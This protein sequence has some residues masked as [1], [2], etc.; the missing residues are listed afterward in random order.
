MMIFIEATDLSSVPSCSVLVPIEQY[1][2][3]L[4]FQGPVY[5]RYRQHVFGHAFLH[6]ADEDARQRWLAA[7]NRY[8]E[9]SDELDYRDM[10]GQLNCSFQ[11]RDELTLIMQ[12]ASEEMEACVV[13]E[14]KI[15]DFCSWPKPALTVHQLQSLVNE[16]LARYQRYSEFLKN[17][18][19]A[20]KESAGFE[21]VEPA[22]VEKFRV[23]PRI[24]RDPLP[25][26]L[27]EYLSYD[28]GAWLWISL[29][30]YPH[31]FWGKLEEEV[32]PQ[33]YDLLKRLGF[34]LV[35]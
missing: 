32:L 17:W 20:G 4:T 22:L 10:H 5:E 15:L 13:H 35:Y 33:F 29:R 9:A 25:I 11:R 2:E 28:V 21:L 18:N 16:L 8:N 34:E 23:E 30:D 26:S 19:S 31:V 6:F 12:E 24:W 1:K 3:Y 7:C 14:E 27:W